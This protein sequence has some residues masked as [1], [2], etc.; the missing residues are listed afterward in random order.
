VVLVSVGVQMYL[1]SN[2]SKLCF[3]VIS[4]RVSTYGVAR[5]LV[6]EQTSPLPVRPVTLCSF[7]ELAGVSE[8]ANAGERRRALFFRGDA[9]PKM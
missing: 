3:T 5:I 9:F 2:Y 7:S 8:G 4:G 1:L 6:G